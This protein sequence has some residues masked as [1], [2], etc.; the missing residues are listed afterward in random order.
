MTGKKFMTKQGEALLRPV[1][2]GDI[3]ALI[4]LNNQCFP[5]MVEQNIIWNRAQLKNHLRLFPDGQ[6]LVEIRG[7]PV[8]AVAS[9]IVHM[10]TDPYRAHTYAGITDGGYFHNHD[11]QG[12]TLY[13][14][15]VY[16]H[17]DFR[18][19]GLGHELYQAR[20][21]LCVRLHLRRILAGGRLDGYAEHAAELSPEQYVDA[22]ETGRL[23]DAV[24]TFQ[25]GEAFVVRGVLRNYIR[26]PKSK[27]AATLIEWINPGYQPNREDQR[28]VRVAAVQY[29]VRRIR[30][31]SEFAEQI[32]YFVETAFDQ[33][34]N[35]LQRLL[36][37]IATG[38]NFQ[39]G[40]ACAL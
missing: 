2:A 1:E 38:S 14:A 32:E 33:S 23:K 16:V 30:D 34:S 10:G 5:A 9:L 13:G 22:V 36:G 24:L 29:Q 18:R 31:F 20:R 39:P 17:P 21:E 35:A 28:K 11:P 37:I 26:D 25:L 8:A 6:L 7:R 40:T 19:L 3:D 12:D 4:E 15:D 27:N